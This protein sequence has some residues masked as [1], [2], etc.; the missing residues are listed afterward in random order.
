MKRLK[1]IFVL[2]LAVLTINMFAIVPANAATYG[3]ANT[4]N[5]SWKTPSSIGILNPILGLVFYNSYTGTATWDGTSWKILLKNLSGTH[6]WNNYRNAQQTAQSMEVGISSTITASSTKS[7]TISKSSGLSIPLEAAK[8]S[9]EIGGSYT[10]S[11]TYQK[12]TGTSAAYTINTK[13]LNGYYAVTHCINA[14]RYNVKLNR[15][16]SSYSSGKLLRYEK[17]NGY[18]ELWYSTSSF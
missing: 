16:G 5:Y 7:Y 1:K 17:T 15:N 9:S 11:K 13:S 18:R 2:V 4:Y 3:G 8:I 10:N 14:D 6:R 12:T